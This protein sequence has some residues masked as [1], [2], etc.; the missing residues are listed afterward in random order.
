[1]TTLSEHFKRS[2]FCCECGCGFNT[3]D[4]E[5]IRVLEDLRTDNV[6]VIILSGCRCVEHNEIVHQWAN[7]D[8]IPFSSNSEH[9]RGKAADIMVQR[10][11]GRKWVTAAPKEVADYLETKYPDTYGIGR[12]D[13]RTHI[14][15]RSHKARWDY[16]D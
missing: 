2:E 1:M 10:Q 15:V 16:A 3:V 9:L 5:L 4:A 14:D 12:Y 13:N 8:Y 11:E 6:R 7:I